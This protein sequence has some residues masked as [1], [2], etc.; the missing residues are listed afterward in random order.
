MT[1]SEEILTVVAP[2]VLLG[3]HLKSHSALAGST[4]ANPR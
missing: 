2:Q 1:M 3:N 4:A